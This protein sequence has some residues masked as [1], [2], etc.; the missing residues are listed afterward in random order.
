MEKTLASWFFMR[1]G[2]STFRLEP[3]KHRQFLFGSRERE[4]RDQILGELEGSSYGGDGFKAV[5]FGDYGR[6]KTHL[7]HNLEFE[8]EKTGLKIKPIYIKCSNFTSK[9]PFQSLFEEMITQFPTADVKRVATAYARL[10]QENKAEPLTKIVHSEDI[11]LVM[12]EGL[13]VVSDSL[14]R[15]CMR[16]LGGEAKVPMEAIKTGIVPQLTDSRRF[17]SVMRGLSH[18]YAEVDGCGIQFFI[19]EAERLNNISNADAFATWLVCLRELT[20]IPRVGMMFFVGANTRNDL[21]VLLM[22][23]EISR[24]IGVVN[25]LELLGPG[26]DDLRAFMLELFSTCIQKGPVPAPHN[27]GMSAAGSDISVPDELVTITN[28]EKKQL[29]TFPFEPDAFD[30]FIE[31]ALMG[32]TSSKPSEVL[33]RILKVAQRAIRRGKRTIDASIVNEISAEGMS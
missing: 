1:P 19:D 15:N 31:N 11:A 13:T 10:V 33:I 28:G 7:C 24:R 14:V 22:Q 21:P 32:Q 4:Q 5:V 8:I 6:G 3:E 27:E 26:R 17:G 12:S 20:E 9:A 29:E 23:E 16:W 2:F 25:Y 30:E 18:M